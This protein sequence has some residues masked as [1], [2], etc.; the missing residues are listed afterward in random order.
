MLNAVNAAISVSCAA[1]ELLENSVRSTKLGY[2]VQTVYGSDLSN[3]FTLTPV[4]Y[5]CPHIETPSDI[6]CKLQE[7]YKHR[8]H[9]L[10][11]MFSSR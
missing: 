8:T 6:H 1:N 10:K 2:K 7:K 3:I 4:I 5:H 9:G 11:C